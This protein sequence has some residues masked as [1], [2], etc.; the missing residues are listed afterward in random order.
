MV[1]CSALKRTY[2]D[3]PSTAEGNVLCIRLDG[4]LAMHVWPHLLG[5]YSRASQRRNAVDHLFQVAQQFHTCDHVTALR[6]PSDRL[7]K[8]DRLSTPWPRQAYRGDTAGVSR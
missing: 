6:I 5:T 2:R 7:A 1:T 3:V 4:S 8:Q